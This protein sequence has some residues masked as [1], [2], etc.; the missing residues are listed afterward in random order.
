MHSTADLEGLN[1]IDASFG[2]R[3]SYCVHCAIVYYVHVIHIIG[4]PGHVYITC[5]RSWSKLSYTL[6]L[7]PDIDIRS[8]VSNQHG[9]KAS[10]G[11]STTSGLGR[12]Q[13]GTKSLGVHIMCNPEGMPLAE[14]YN[15]QLLT[16]RVQG[17]V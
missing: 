16:V 7:A 15:K 3:G 6:N 11:F 12:Q 5:P 10:S 9:S 14:C 4:K 8:Y 13:G 17:A 1:E 2:P